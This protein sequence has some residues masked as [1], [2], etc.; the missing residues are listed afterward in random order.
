MQTPAPARLPDQNVV[1]SAV[2]GSPS[3]GVE[4]APPVYKP[5]E[6]PPVYDVFTHPYL[7]GYG[8]RGSPE[9]DAREGERGRERARVVAATGRDRDRVVR[10]NGWI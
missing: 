10:A 1:S 8:V 2:G 9:Q 6:E 5:N 4:E 7:Q 3:E